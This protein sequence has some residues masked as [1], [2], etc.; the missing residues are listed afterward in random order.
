M[1]RKVAKA[2][3]VF[4]TH[5]EPSQ[6]MACIVSEGFPALMWDAS[7]EKP[8]KAWKSSVTGQN[9]DDHRPQE[10]VSSLEWHKRGINKA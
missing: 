3:D 8:K 2:C 4:G 10:Q 9:E 1:N 7:H 5:K 6:L